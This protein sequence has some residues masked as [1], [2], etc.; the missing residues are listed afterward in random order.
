MSKNKLLFLSLILLVSTLSCKKQLNV[1]NPNE[2]TIPQD[3]NNQTGLIAFAQGAVYIDGFYNSNAYNW[4]GNGY[5]SL[6]YGYSELLGD[7]IGSTDANEAVNTINIP[8]YVILDNG[9]QFPATPNQANSAALRVSNTRSSTA[10]GYNPFYYQWA[11]MYILNGAC[12]TILST[13]P[14][15]KLT[16]DTATVAN[17]IRAWAYFWKGYAYSVIGS[18][19]TAG[20]VVNTAGATNNNFL[21]KDSIIAASNSWFSLAAT[22]LGLIPAGSSDYTNTLGGLIP[23]FCQATPHG[24]IPTPTMW[25]HNINTMLARNILV[26]KLAPFVQGNLSATITGSSIIPMASSDWTNVLNY[27]T[28]GVQ[29]GDGVFTATSAPEN[30]IYPANTG[31]PSLMAAG[32]YTNTVFQV[33]LRFTQNFNPADQRFIQN[34][35]DSLTPF[36]NDYFSTPY[37]LSNVPNISPTVMTYGDQTT[38]DYEL[39]IGAS[40]EENALMLAEANL[41]LGSISAA[42]PYI[43]AVRQYQGAG[44]GVPPLAGTTPTAA[45]AYQQLV[46]ERRVALFDRG[47]SF[48]DA[49]RWGWTYD[50]SKG[51]GSY[52][53]QMIY[54]PSSGSPVTNVNVTF[55][56]NFM[57]YWDVPADE[58]ILN[59]PSSA[60]AKLVLN[61]NY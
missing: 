4:L 9:T 25:I 12:N 49:R 18:Q 39:F 6:N 35:Y 38:G 10:A 53:N 42:L 28:N 32:N 30:G 3:V 60:T 24:G 61:P 34:F 22:T 16:G 11:N 46:S 33:G 20:L 17:T 54:T 26:N 45:Q 41:R 48:W 31:S 7:M 56:Y 52:G 21:V 58:V 19:Y 40:Y 15:I 36:Y 14:S 27:A 51:G 1:G 13:M 5:F 57:D 55:N 59:P 50:I 23:A 8:E 47:L 43:D 2:P 29:P 37:A 44:S